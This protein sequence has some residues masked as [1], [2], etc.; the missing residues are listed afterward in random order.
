MTPDQWREIRDLLAVLI[1]LPAKDR[2]AYLEEACHGDASLRAELESLISAH[3]IAD[4]GHFERL[5]LPT[6]LKEE[7]QSD[8]EPVCEFVGRRIGAYRIEAEIG[9]GGMGQVFR[10]RRADDR[11]SK[12]VAIKLLDRSTISE[13]SLQ[14]FRHEREILAN[15]EHSNIAR[16][17]DAGESEEGVPYFVMEYVDGDPLDVYCDAHRLTIEQRLRLFLKVC[18]AVHYAHQNLVIHRDLKPA[19]IL[20]SQR[21]E[22]KLLDFGIAKIDNANANTRTLTAWR[23]LTPAYA[24]PEQLLGRP[25]NIATDI[26]SLALV[27]YELL[28]GRY[29]YGERQSAP[30]LQRAIVEEDPQRLSAAVFRSPADAGEGATAEKISDARQ[31]T[32]Q[33][34]SSVLRG[35]LESIVLKAIRKEPSQRYASVERLSEDIESYLH[36]LPVRAR[37]GA[38][39]YRVRKF[40]V[41][42]RGAVVAGCFIY[43]LLLAGIALVLREARI[44][45]LQQARA[46]RRFNDVRKL[47]NSLLFE[48]HDTIQDLPGSTPARKLIVERSLQ[49]LD[50]LSSES[51]NDLGLLRELAT[52]YTRVGELQG[53]PLANNLG[54]TSNSLAS[55]QKALNMR[56]RLA[57]RP[58]AEWQDR[59]NLAESYRRMAEDL[60]AV[61]S[62]SAAAND[63]QKA[64]TI[65]EAMSK[66]SPNDLNVLYELGSDYEVLSM[67]QGGDLSQKAL[68]VQD[69]VLSLDPS[70]LSARRA[71]ANDLFHIGNEQSDAGH[72]REALAS[73]KDALPILLSISAP[74][75]RRRAAAVYNQMGMLYSRTGDYK[76][77]E[78]NHR[79]ALEIYKK[80][81]AEDPKNAL[82]RQGLAISYVNFGDSESQQGHFAESVADINNGMTIMKAIVEGDPTSEQRDILAQIHMS[83]AN[84]F[85]RV[86]KFP[87]AIREYRIALQIR[88]GIH[89]S[90]SAV[91]VAGIAECKVS[92]AEAERRSGDLAAAGA[93]FQEALTLSEPQ[94]NANDSTL[95]RAAANAYAG[96]GDIAV[97]TGSRLPAPTK[98]RY[99][100]RAIQCYKRS[101]EV[102]RQ[103]RLWAPDD[104]ANFDAADVE[105]R[106]RQ[107]QSVVSKLAIGPGNSRPNE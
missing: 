22:P 84:V 3:E 16:L 37:Q 92:I 55:Y 28:T 102:G 39:T 51:G 34:L 87:D 68:A 8:V 29:A 6:D 97:A 4:A 23:A 41:R 24:S 79:K 38:T 91:G 48:L 31:A 43:L 44:A 35:D 70:N 66:V 1:E 46:E 67:I 81:V 90:N 61:G 105:R 85:A 5:P 9:R 80:L 14:L 54:Q 40:V 15:L 20:V 65:T 77:C 27:L 10:A 58:N 56:Q 94:L 62:A 60:K 106:L 18:A 7:S 82:F 78:E 12:E 52:A 26:Y 64:I 88:E 13:R 75:D 101:L 107:I 17:L 71:R 36:D 95:R 98:Q 59:L 57:E 53:Q 76:L 93:D 25:L 32:P 21:G 45:R 99:W 100:E 42:N 11:F 103:V 63:L 50:S 96:L 49:Y 86:K 89:R 30:E 2:S 69:R 19:N 33:K 74:R 104:P 73:F 83:L 47:A 72:T